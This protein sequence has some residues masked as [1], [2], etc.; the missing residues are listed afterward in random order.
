MR[1]KSRERDG[2][3]I[4]DLSGDITIGQGDVDLRK[5]ISETDSQR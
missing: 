2:V 4:L 3:T 5:E 1:V